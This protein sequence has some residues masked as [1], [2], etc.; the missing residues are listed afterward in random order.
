MLGRD[1]DNTFYKY[2]YG[3]S[4]IFRYLQLDDGYFT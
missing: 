3:Y 1:L 2:M 4:H